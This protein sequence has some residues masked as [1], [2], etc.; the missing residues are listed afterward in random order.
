VLTTY[1]D[2]NPI[3]DALPNIRFGDVQM[4]G[5]TGCNHYW[6]SYQITEDAISFDS[7]FRNEIGCMEPEGV[8]DQ[9]RTY[10]DLLMSADRFELC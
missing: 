9:E 3:D 10:L 2:A 7:I 6:G 8:M 4:S 5:T 1:N